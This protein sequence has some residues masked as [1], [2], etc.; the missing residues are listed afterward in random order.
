MTLLDRCQPLRDR[1]ESLKA[2]Q[3]SSIEADNLSKRLS[4]ARELIDSVRPVYD[5][6]KL[7]QE[8]DIEIDLS[9]LDQAD[10]SAPLGKIIERFTDKPEAASLTKRK[11]WT[12]LQEFASDWR[13][14]LNAEAHRSWKGFIDH[15]CLGQSPEAL[16]TT[17]A[18]TETNRRVLEQFGAIYR[19]LKALRDEFPEDSKTI[20]Y[21]LKLSDELKSASEGFDYEVPKDVKA[22]LAAI[23]KEG[24]ASLD[25]LTQEVLAWLRDNQSESQY[26]IV[27]KR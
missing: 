16:R 20:R 14:K 26:Q 19:D 8:N 15:L 5:R 18:Q 3:G 4:E 23:H 25:L 10:P 24:G 22:F 13:K 11:D 17:L 6:V 12:T 7:L 9:A 2:S 27:G 1:L 21:A